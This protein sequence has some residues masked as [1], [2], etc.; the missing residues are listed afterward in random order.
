MCKLRI[1]APPPE[2]KAL[3]EELRSF[4]ISAVLKVFRSL[5]YKEI[6]LLFERNETK[7][8]KFKFQKQFYLNYSMY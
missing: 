1:K 3:V 2:R 8:L 7:V 5:M 6:L 4:W